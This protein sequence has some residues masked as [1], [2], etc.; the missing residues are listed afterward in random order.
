M[1]GYGNLQDEWHARQGHPTRAGAKR[2][3]SAKVQGGPVVRLRDQRH[4][5]AIMLINHTRKMKV[6]ITLPTYRRSRWLL[7]GQVGVSL[8]APSSSART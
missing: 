2:R 5:F 1:D 7:P 6:L 4:A 8:Q 3:R